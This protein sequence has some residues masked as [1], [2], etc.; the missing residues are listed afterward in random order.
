MILEEFV[1]GI[2]SARSGF[3]YEANG[4]NPDKGISFKAGYAAGV[5]TRPVRIVNYLL[6]VPQESL[7]PRTEDFTI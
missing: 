2:R 1:E 5:L 3:N 6:D 7:N 4:Y